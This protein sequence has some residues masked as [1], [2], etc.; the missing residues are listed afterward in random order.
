MEAQNPYQ[1]PSADVSAQHTGG[2]DET[3]PFSPSGRFGRLSYIAWGVIVG[4]LGNVVTAIFGG[5]AA[6]V[7]QH[8][9]SGAPILPDISGPAM[10]AIVVVS[11]ISLVLY[12]IFS[13]R[14]CH[15][16]NGSGWLV[17]IGLIPLANLVFFLYLWLKG[18]DDGANNYG[19]PRVTPGWER[20]VGIIGVVL[21]VAMVVVVIGSAVMAVV[22]ASSGGA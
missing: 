6:F 10:A 3:S 1:P 11:L 5:G 22:L 17:L 21:I 2:N 8:D 7:P 12:V 4:V 20:V 16:F 18:G 14:R 13:I 19:P 15:D 9:A